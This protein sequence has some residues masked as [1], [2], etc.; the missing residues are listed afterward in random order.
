MGT[1]AFLAV[2]I[3][4]FGGPLALAALYAPTIVGD[5]TASA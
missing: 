2:A 1:P 5:T 3:T 4:S